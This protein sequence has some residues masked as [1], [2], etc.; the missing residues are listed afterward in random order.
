MAQLVPRELAVAFSF[1]DPAGEQQP[2]AVERID[3]RA[4]RSGPGECCEQVTQRVLNGAVGVK[5]DV[6]GRVIDQA[7][8]ERH[9][10]LA[11]AGLGQDPALQPGA[12]E[13]QL[14][15]GHRALQAEQ[16]AVVEVGRVI[17]PVLVADQRSRE[18]GDLQQS[19]PVGVVACQPR[20]LQAE[21]DPGLPEADVGHEPLEPL[22]I[23]GARAGLTLVGVDHDDLLDRPAKRDRALPQRVLA[24]RGLGVVLDLAQRR[25]AHIQIRRPRQ[26]LGA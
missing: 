25:L 8:G 24:L 4:R 3:D 17:E 19:V 9:R 6:P 16:Q 20:D 1:A 7:D 13:V 26:V 2:V 12:D 21:H 15:L 5:H 23:G 22:A 11:A 18:R 10:K 14:G